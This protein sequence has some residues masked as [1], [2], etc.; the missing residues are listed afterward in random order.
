MSLLRNCQDVGTA[1]SQ[2]FF[3]FIIR[4]MITADA[5]FQGKTVHQAPVLFRRYVTGL[6]RSARPLE[7]AVRQA[8][9]AQTKTIPFIDQAFYSV[10]PGSAEEKEGSLLKRFQAI[11][12]SDNCS[13]TINA[14]A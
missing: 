14:A 10:F 4:F 12:K 5:A 7:P 11:I 8:L 3:G 9:I 6:I 13:Q 1:G 2:R